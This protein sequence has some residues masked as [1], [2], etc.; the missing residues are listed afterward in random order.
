MAWNRT[1]A[2]KKKNTTQST[3]PAVSTAV[4]ILKID[5]NCKKM[6]CS[7]LSI[8]L[9]RKRKVENKENDDDGIF[10]IAIKNVLQVFSCWRL[11]LGVFK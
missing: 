3:A 8:F 2:S 1:H 9:S 10:F 7:G 5:E 4:R 11:K 6:K